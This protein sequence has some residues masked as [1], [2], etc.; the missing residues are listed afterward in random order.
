VVL[1][2]LI[3]QFP[4]ESSSDRQELTRKGPAWQRESV[5]PQILH[6]SRSRWLITSAWLKDI[7]IRTDFHPHYG[8]FTAKSNRTL[9]FTSWQKAT[10]EL[11]PATQASQQQSCIQDCFSGPYPID[12]S[13]P[14]RCSWRIYLLV[15]SFLWRYST[16]VVF[17]SV[18]HNLCNIQCTAHTTGKWNH[19]VL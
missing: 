7:H 17:M 5:W 11:S 4:T 19:T 10:P 1:T 12:L 3:T 15:L 8:D 16:L 6:T 14:N 9:L 18:R 13:H 2:P